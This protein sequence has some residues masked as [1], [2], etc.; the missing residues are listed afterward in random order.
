MATNNAVNTSLSGST[1]T[2]N[3]VGSI[4][5]TLTGTTTLSTT[6]T[7]ALNIQNAGS[8]ASETLSSYINS[9]TSSNIRYNKSRSTV[10]GS[11]TTVQSGDAAGNISFFGDDG[12]QFS[13][14]G[15]IQCVVTGT[16][17]TGIVPGQLLFNTTNSSGVSTLSMYID[18]NSRVYCLESIVTQPAN[19]QSSSLAVASN[20]HNTAGYD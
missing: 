12:T 2:G 4:S 11:F 13:K 5:P 14:C 20:Y 10:I 3:F 16:V 1:G 17:S 18:S 19:S 15:S 9:T 7:S 8:S 6:N